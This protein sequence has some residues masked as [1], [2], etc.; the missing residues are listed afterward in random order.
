[1]RPI[2]R[3][4]HGREGGRREKREGIIAH[5]AHRMQERKRREGKEIEIGG[6]YYYFF[7][8]LRCLFAPAGRRLV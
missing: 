2:P 6:D 8:S 3:T 5:S 7:P 4:C 1:M